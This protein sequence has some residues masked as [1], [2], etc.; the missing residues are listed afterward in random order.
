MCVELLLDV[1]GRQ[2]KKGHLAELLVASTQLFH[3]GLSDRGHRAPR[4]G[5]YSFPHSKED[6]LSGFREGMFVGRS[7]ARPH[8]S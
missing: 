4:A 5:V 8:G 2:E 3:L 7:M 1:Q 6:S